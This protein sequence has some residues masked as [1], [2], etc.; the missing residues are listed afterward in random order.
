M[1]ERSTAVVMD[2]VAGSSDDRQGMASTTGTFEGTGRIPRGRQ[3]GSIVACPDGR[4]VVLFGGKLRWGIPL[5]RRPID[6]PS[7]CFSVVWH[8]RWR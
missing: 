8:R 3:F 6:C 4:S 2:S 1:H 5:H 7:V